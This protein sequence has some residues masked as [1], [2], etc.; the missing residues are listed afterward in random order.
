MPHTANSETALE[1]DPPTPEV[2]PLALHLAHVV[3]CPPVGAAHGAQDLAAVGGTAGAFVG[4][5]REQQYRVA[6][7]WVGGLGDTSSN[8]IKQGI[9]RTFNIEKA[10]DVRLAYPEGVVHRS[11][12]NPPRPGGGTR[13]RR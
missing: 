8:S 12:C 7:S 1:A 10:S 13:C 4:H 6:W 11:R 9:N 2:A 5:C 3:V